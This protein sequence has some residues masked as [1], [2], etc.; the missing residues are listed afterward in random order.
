M[1]CGAST[2][3]QLSVCIL[4]VEQMDV[5]P[6]LGFVFPILLFTDSPPI[7]YPMVH[8]PG[9]MLLDLCSNELKAPT[10]LREF[11]SQG[12]LHFLW[13]RLPLLEA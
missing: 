7:A 11:S 6:Y 9:C 2:H 8:A 3:K 5:S 1:S 13:I 10:K 4:N 12:Q